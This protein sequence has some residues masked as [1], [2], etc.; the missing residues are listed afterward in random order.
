[1][2]LRRIKPR[3]PREATIALI[4]I[5]FLMLVFFLIAGTIAPPLDARVTLVDT[6]DLEGRPPPDAGVLLPDGTLLWQGAPITAAELAGMGPEPRVIP[7]RAVPAHILVRMAGQI[8][9]AGA[10]RVWIVTE[11]GLQ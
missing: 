1:M 8:R 9:A 4:N 5:V 3:R 10:H 11:R 6:T 2:S 7:D